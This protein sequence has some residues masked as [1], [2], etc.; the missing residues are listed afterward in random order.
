[1]PRVHT[2]KFRVEQWIAEHLDGS[3]WTAREI[4]HAA[5]ASPA[6]VRNTIH[7]LRANG[8]ISVKRSEYRGIHTNWSFRRKEGSEWGKGKG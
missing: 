1:M 4:A 7:E 3:F 8:F 6:V 2:Q 5:K